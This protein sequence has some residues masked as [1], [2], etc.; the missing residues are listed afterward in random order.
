M[1][2]ESTITIRRAPLALFDALKA[3]MDCGPR[4]D[5]SSSMMRREGDDVII[6][7]KASD[8]TA[9]RAAANSMAKLFITFEN[10]QGIDDGQ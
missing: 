2:L 5:R 1:Q 7:I 8:A 6:S 4:N 10:M 3:E 9:Y